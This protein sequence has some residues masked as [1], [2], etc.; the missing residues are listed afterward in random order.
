MKSK[1]GLNYN[2]KK[3]GVKFPTYLFLFLFSIFI[4]SSSVIGLG[5]YPWVGGQDYDYNQGRGFFPPTTDIEFATRQITN[6]LQA[7][8]VS[9][10][11]NDGV[12]E[13]IVLDGDTIKLYHGHG[14]EIVD[15]VSIPNLDRYSNM[16][17]YDIDGDSLKEVIIVREFD[18]KIDIFEYNTTFILQNTV[19]YSSK[20]QS[21]DG[22]TVISCGGVDSC[23]LVYSQS[24]S[25]RG[26]GVSTHIRALP[27]SS[28][29]V[30]ESYQLR[31][32]PSTPYHIFCMP[33]IRSMPYIDYDGNGE[34]EYVVSFLQ[35]S[36]SGNENYYISYISV[37]ATNDITGSERIDKE[38]GNL[39][40]GIF[41]CEE[42]T[43]N[44][45]ITSPIV[46]DFDGASSN[47]L[48]TVIG[49]QKDADE[50]KIHSWRSDGTQ[51]DTYPAFFDADGIIISNPII[52][53]IDPDSEGSVDFCVM[54]YQ[55]N[56]GEI[57]L[58]CASEQGGGLFDPESDEFEYDVSGLYNIT[59]EY[60]FYNNM[61]HAVQH[62][63]ETTGGQDLN[64]IITPYGIF[65]IDYEGN[66]EL[67]MLY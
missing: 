66:N 53:N 51:L 26:A 16:L 2:V 40:D 64:E 50:F 58:L 17:A 28:T 46:Y 31:A 47:G 37:N 62:S 13:I 61:I 15:G 10:L 39:K 65:T 49:I 12:N 9:D 8:I 59:K 45:Y 34:K 36:S 27:F 21:I 42:E 63:S 41:N 56:I 60:D 24:R 22:Q 23:M 43:V 11:N 44:A 55:D 25:V 7:P 1:K 3:S 20:T 38:M 19:S 29:A 5:T 57:D 6:P 35:T 52:A 30:R 54:G 4:L 14:L 18:E 32:S 33:K 67:L 48:E